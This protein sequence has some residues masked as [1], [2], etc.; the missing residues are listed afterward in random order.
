[1]TLMIN[2]N[3]GLMN[4]AVKDNAGMDVI[5]IATSSRKHQI[6]LQNRLHELKGA[7]IKPSAYIICIVE[8]WPKGAGNGLGTLYAF[9][10]ARE[11]ARSTWGI[12][13]LEKM[14]R[15][16]SVALY[17]TAGNGSRM[18][19][20][21]AAEGG[22][23]PLIKLPGKIEDN[24]T[25]SLISLLEAVIKQTS[26]YALPSKG[27]LSVFWSDQIF[28]P[29]EPLHETSH[30]HIDIYAQ[31]VPFPSES[32]WNA[33]GYAHYG[34]VHPEAKLLVEKVDYNTYIEIL[35]KYHIPA[36]SYLGLSLGCFSLSLPMLKS[37][38]DF[39]QDDLLAKHS[40]M[41]TD[42]H[43]WMPLM[44]DQDTYVNLLVN[45]NHSRESCELHYSRMKSFKEA[46]KKEHHGH[47]FDIKDIGLGSYW[48][49]F[50]TLSKYFHNNMLAIQKNT[51][52]E[53]LK[54]FYGWALQGRSPRY[55]H[56]SCDDGS[57]L[58]NCNI[59]SGRIKNS[60]LMNVTANHVEIEE[61]MILNSGF[62]DLKA[63]RNLI[64]HCHEKEDCEM[65]P[66]LA[67]VDVPLDASKQYLK[68][69]S[70][71]DKDA[72]EDW[73]SRLPSNPLSFAELNQ[74]IHSV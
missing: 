72:K 24:H 66:G 40:Q 29:T 2:T 20:L 54:Q 4:A 14:A 50:G 22:C 56:L 61:S 15:G 37:L 12:D 74:L 41:S 46:F 63:C 73:E 70:P 64:Y 57:I 1:M 7:L 30:A 69:T 59:A 25:F 36:S 23:K 18:F 65:T 55:N 6:L 58:Y 60:I 43:F 27:R 71:L 13:L 5:I 10:Q 17:H 33:Y 39:F 49:D 67:K 62:H 11:V 34:M 8:D 42:L 52:G 28:I 68:F 45:K 53:A 44:H 9:K 51:Q 19:P 16:S 26:I 47:L 32:N 38:M 3:I 35:N 21:T 31:Y 48:W